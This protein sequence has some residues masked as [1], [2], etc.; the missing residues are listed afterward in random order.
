MQPCE[1]DYLTISRM[2]PLRDVFSCK[3][4]FEWFVAVVMNFSASHSICRAAV[5]DS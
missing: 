1:A 5:P 3:D 2:L 4:Y